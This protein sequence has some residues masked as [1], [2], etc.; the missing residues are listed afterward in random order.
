MYG[1]GDHERQLR[2]ARVVRIRLTSR[3]VKDIPTAAFDDGAPLIVDLGTPVLAILG[4]ERPVQL[5]RQSITD[6][7]N[8]VKIAPR[9]IKKGQTITINVL[10][11]EIPNIEVISPLIDVKVG[12]KTGSWLSR[13]GLRS[14][15]TDPEN[16]SNTGELAGI[17]A[18]AGVVVAGVAI[19][20]AISSPSGSVLINPQSTVTVTVTGS[21]H[22]LSLT[23]KC[24]IRRQYSR[25]VQ[26]PH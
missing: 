14:A 20:V 4:N 26:Q 22:P 6:E 15:D 1:E 7:G 18:V 16:V 19:W 11:D 17:A 2:Q 23:L 10:V 5:S 12:Q 24:Q 9:L 21:S 8:Q 25:K 3:S 13:L